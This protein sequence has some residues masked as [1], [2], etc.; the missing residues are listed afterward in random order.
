MNNREFRIAHQNILYSTCDSLS[1]KIRTKA[2]SKCFWVFPRHRSEIRS[3]Y[4]RLKIR[5]I[6][7]LYDFLRD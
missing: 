1:K 7:S 3:N 4:D 5:R 2:V 6:G